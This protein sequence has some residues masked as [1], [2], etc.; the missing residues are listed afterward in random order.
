MNIKEKGDYN[1]EWNS[2]D[3]EK[4]P[5]VELCSHGNEVSGFVINKHITSP[6][7]RIFSLHYK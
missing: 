5:V 3:L 6:K 4:G 7:R 1:D 2:T